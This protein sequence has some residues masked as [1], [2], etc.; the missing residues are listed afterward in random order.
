[1]KTALMQNH[2]FRPRRAESGHAMIVALLLLLIVMSISAV[3]F[4]RS[5][6]T[7]RLAARATDYAEVE[8][9]SDGLIEYAYG[10]W[11]GDTLQKDRRLTVAEAAAL[12][13][14]GVPT[15]PGVTSVPGFALS[16]SPADSFGD[17]ATTEGRVLTYLS[18]YPGWKG[19]SYNYV[20]MV[21]MKQTS[22]ISANS[23]TPA[24]A[25]TKRVF[26]YT[27]VPLFQSMY[28]FEDTL[29]IYRP[30]PMI[31]NGLVHSNSRLLLSGSEDQSGVELN[32]QGYV[33]YAGGSTST[34]GYSTTEAP[35]GGLAWSGASLSDM[36]PPT[37]SNGGESAQLSKSQ[38]YEP[39]GNKPATV[40]DTADANPNN[41]GFRELIELPVAGFTDP[42]EISKRRL[43][44][45]AGIIVRINGSTITSANRNANVTVTTQNGTTLTA[46][47][48]TNIKNAVLSKATVYDQREGKS[49][50]MANVSVANLTSV[51]NT[52]SGFN[53]ILYVY[54]DTA[55]VTGDNEV[56]TIRLQDG[57]TLPNA[58]LTIASQNPV[59]VQ[60]DYNTGST[61]STRDTV[62]SNNGGNP[63]NTDSP[64]APGYTRKAAAILADAVMLLSN[65][66]ND[67]NAS[68]TDVNARPASHTTYNMAIMAG[69]IPSGF[70]PDGSGPK[71][72]YGYSG[73]ANNFPRFLESWTSDSCTYY[74]S[75]VELFKSTIFTGKWDTGIIYR[76]PN[77]RWN[78][79][80]NFTDNPP[81]GSIDAVVLSRGSW[82]RLF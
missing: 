44:T 17:P 11:K 69:F 81:P 10:V 76:P 19:Y 82:A 65:N 71:A 40:I 8:R 78:F 54:D 20:A 22:G 45:K 25:G 7:A 66:W 59:Y 80:T 50:D 75:M 55:Q 35:Y 37:Y 67:S 13:S 16:I 36:E 56:K 52:A 53:G 18:D 49:V 6:G 27:E 58:G 12:T 14:T 46:T 70:D 26:Q 60:G 1:M 2:S 64:T 21:K 48:V 9:T 5:S 38:R 68:N 31:V 24:T 42:S 28:F 30:A 32:M 43:S 3:S 47:Q 34:P 77:R 72:P 41:D 33:S 51:L 23:G 61:S 39:L 57:G 63:N 62:P 79:D 74:G 15:F 4:S 73:G 29:E